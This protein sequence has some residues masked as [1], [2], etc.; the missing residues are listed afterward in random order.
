MIG[1]KQGFHNATQGYEIEI[2][3]DQR[4]LALNQDHLQAAPQAVTYTYERTQVC[5]RGCACVCV[6]IYG[7]AHGC[8]RGCV[9]KATKTTRT[10]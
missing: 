1:L 8:V 6:C 3:E 4:V 5:V 2:S 7:W 9:H 10:H